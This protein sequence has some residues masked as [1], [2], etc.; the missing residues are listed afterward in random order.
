MS[1]ELPPVVGIRSSVPH[2]IF[3]AAQLHLREFPHDF[4]IRF[5]ERFL[6]RYYLT[7]AESPHAEAFVAID[8]R[9]GRVVGTLLGTLDTPAH[10]G[11]LVRRHG[12]GLASFAL[13]GALRDPGLG[14]DLLRTRAVRYARGIARYLFRRRSSCEV[15]EHKDERIGLLAHV[16]VDSGWRGLGIGRS[17]VAAYETRTREAGLDRLELVTLPDERGAGSF[18]D[19]I[20]W[21]YEG[22]RVSRS[23]ERFALYALSLTKGPPPTK[24]IGG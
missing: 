9:T 10:Y 1:G 23:G 16:A 19:K 24:H 21:K 8:Y 14:G 13:L 4:I 22:E 18:Y 2:D 17:L 5:G 3:Q 11:F 15:K 20:G 7:F 12:L 6:A